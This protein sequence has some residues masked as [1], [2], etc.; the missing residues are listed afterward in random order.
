[1]RV[2]SGPLITSL[3]VTTLAATTTPAAAEEPG[4]GIV[5]QFRIG[6]LMHDPAIWS[7]RSKEDGVDLNLDAVFDYEMLDVLGGTIRPYAGVSLSLQG[8]TSRAHAGLVWQYMAGP[9]YFDLGLGAAIHNGKLDH[10]GHDR[11][12]LGSRVL[13][14]VP[15]ELGF[16][17]D[18]HNRVGVYFEHSSNANLAEPNTGIDAIG[19]RYTYQF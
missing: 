10:P 6:A 7:K 13:F 12:A 15:V 4:L 17:L 5:H 18:E 9:V 19:L 8:D 2:L 11:K 1:M 3:F 14:H 16:T